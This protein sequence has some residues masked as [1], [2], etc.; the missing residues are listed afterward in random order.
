MTRYVKPD[1]LAPEIGRSVHPTVRRPE[2]SVF[3]GWGPRI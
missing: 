1:P 2:P 3:E